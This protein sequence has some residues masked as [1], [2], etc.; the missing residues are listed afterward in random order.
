MSEEQL[1]ALTIAIGLMKRE[2]IHQ[3]AQVLKDLRTELSARR[4]VSGQDVPRALTDE[5]MT[6]I[7]RKWM[8]PD[9]E[10]PPEF[11]WGDLYD[12]IRECLTAAGAK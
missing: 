11:Y 5:Q 1:T 6:A 8:K 3:N 10:P 9:S 12:C 7:V 4:T 2:G